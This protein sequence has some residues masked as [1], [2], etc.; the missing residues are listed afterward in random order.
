[1]TP[2]FA[3]IYDATVSQG[4]AAKDVTRIETEVGRLGIQGPVLREGFHDVPSALQDALREGVKNLIFVG[5]DVWFLQWIPWFSK[6]KGVSI[7]FL[8]IEHSPLSRALGMPLGGAAVGILAA[9]VLKVFDLGVVN[10]RPFLTEAIAQQTSARL[11]FE[12]SY[13]VRAKTPSPLAI[14]NFAIHSKTGEV[15]SVPTDGQ[16]EAVLQTPIERSILFGVWKKTELEETRIA[17]SRGVVSDEGRP[18]QFL[19]D[20]LPLTGKE[21]VFDIMPS[22]LPL[23]VGPDRLFG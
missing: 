22:V 20:G 15:L 14:Q 16:L 17:F 10:G 18:V 19:V 2:T 7:G 6:Q 13:A 11:E 21:V 3:Y 4:G 8:P 9:R 5:S 12:G 1:M 23:I